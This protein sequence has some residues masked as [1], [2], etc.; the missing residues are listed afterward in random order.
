MRTA[1]ESFSRYVPVGVVRDLLGRGEA[2]RIGG[3]IEVLS[4]LFSDIHD[5]TAIAESMGPDLLARHLTDYFGAIQEVLDQHHATVDK[6]IGDAVLAFWGAPHFDPLH[7]LHA[8]QAALA[9]RQKIAEF[10]R[11]AAARGQPPLRTSFGI[12]TGPVVV[13][14]VGSPSRL[15]YSVLGNT[16][17][18][19]SRLEG[20]NRHYGTDILVSKAVVEATGDTFL[21]RRV[22]CV[23][24]KGAASAM[25]I[26]EPLGARGQ[27]PDEIIAFKTAY[28]AGLAA[29]QSRAFQEAVAIFSRLNEKHPDNQ[30]VQVLLR[31]SRE[32]EA[33]PPSA[34]G[35][36][37]FRFQSK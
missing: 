24:V 36:L 35:D 31:R 26:Y 8:V 10:N 16:V 27:V 23:A 11:A 14:N 34:D 18:I 6:F 13:G 5:F 21:W 12:A 20:I 15:N 22:D 37:T 30:S 2:A 33:N 1:L 9:C 25:E 28:E 32:A 19:A 3:R 7:A 29:Y 4:V 17:N